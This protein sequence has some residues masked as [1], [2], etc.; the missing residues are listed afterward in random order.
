MHGIHAKFLLQFP[1]GFVKMA[2]SKYQVFLSVMESRN[3]TKSAEQLGYT[4]PSISHILSSMEKEIGA[5]LFIRTKRGVFPTGTALFLEKHVRQI[6]AAED[7]LTQDIFLMQGI[8][9]G[10]IRIGSYLSI[11][12]QWLPHIVST[13]LAKHPQVE[14]EFFIGTNEE[15]AQWLLDG[16]LD[17]ALTSDPIPEKFEFMCLYKDPILA[18]LPQ[19]N[20]L[21]ECL[22]IDLHDLAQYPFIIPCEE[23]DKKISTIMDNEGIPFH[24]RFLTRGG[25]PTLAMINQ[26]LGVTLTHKLPL[27]SDLAS[28]RNIVAR[29]IRQ[30]FSRNLGICCRSFASVSRLERAF[31]QDVTDYAQLL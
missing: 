31:I 8:E 22:A 4:Q 7:A 12:T 5:P 1:E 24:I 9:V 28:F 30:E 26:G 15:L 6:V 18:V 25:S 17:F 29:P 20:P 2:N 10:K 19:D 23:S 21:T 11:S 27:L 3:L 16:K 14:L 13:F